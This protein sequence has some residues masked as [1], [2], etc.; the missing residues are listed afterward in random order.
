V[1]RKTTLV[2][3]QIRDERVIVREK[4]ELSINPAQFHEYFEDDP[5]LNKPVSWRDHS[6]QLGGRFQSGH[7]RTCMEKQAELDVGSD[8][9]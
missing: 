9:R 7:H 6:T 4:D 1:T 3:R 8:V 5:L 2:V